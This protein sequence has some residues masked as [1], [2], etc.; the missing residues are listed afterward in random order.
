MLGYYDKGVQVCDKCP[1][2]CSVCSSSSEC[3]ACFKGYY[4]SFDNLC[5]TS[6]PV[7]AYVVEN[8][9]ACKRCYYDCYTCQS[10]GECLTC[11]AI[12]DFREID[13]NSGRCLC[14][15]GYYDNFAQKC[16]QCSYNCTVCSA[17][18]MCSSCRNGFELIK[19]LCISLCDIRFVRDSSNT[20][21]I[22]CP[23]DCL[24]CDNNSNC[25]TCS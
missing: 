12:A 10:Y 8:T 21:C 2:G 9:Y 16:L 13:L 22:P 14:Q 20:S 5:Y 4:L 3:S 6:C 23:Y 11:N 1:E 17:P 25:L 15:I 24:S 7:R 19:T 18:N